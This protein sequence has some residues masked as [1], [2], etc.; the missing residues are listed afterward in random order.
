VGFERNPADAAADTLFRR[1]IG[2]HTVALSH[3]AGDL[4]TPAGWP[5]PRRTIVQ[6]DLSSRALA[7]R[8][9]ADCSLAARRFALLRA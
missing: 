2:V 3:G 1:K 8:L 7:G 9:P 6:R 5:N 4:S